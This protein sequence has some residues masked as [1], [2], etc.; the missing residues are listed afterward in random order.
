MYTNDKK[1]QTPT[2]QTKKKRCTD[3]NHL[4]IG[5]HII[6]KRLHQRPYFRVVHPPMPQLK[7]LV[8][9]IEASDR[10]G[11]LRLKKVLPG[12]QQVRATIVAINNLLTCTQYS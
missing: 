6:H 3:L 5:L 4:L 7:K 2:C 8:N 1:T 10:I 12:S 9:K 11:R